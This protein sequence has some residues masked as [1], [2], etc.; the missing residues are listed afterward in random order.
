MII[1]YFKVTHHEGSV[2]QWDQVSVRGSSYSL[3]NGGHVCG[4]NTMTA[5][6]VKLGSGGIN[7][8]YTGQTKVK[9]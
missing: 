4:D 3:G 6:D 1:I 8:R 9:F 5:G 7:G 2:E